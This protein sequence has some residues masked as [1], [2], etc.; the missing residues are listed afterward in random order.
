MDKMIRN[1]GTIQ[2][3]AIPRKKRTTNSE[4][5]LLQGMCR[6]RIPPLAEGLAICCM[7]E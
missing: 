3:S 2:A 6:R 5:K 7:E 4:A 1:A